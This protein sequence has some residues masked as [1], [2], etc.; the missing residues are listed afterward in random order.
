MKG[1]SHRPL[2]DMESNGVYFDVNDLLLVGDESL[3]CNY[4]GLPSVKSY[5]IIVGDE[6][7]E[8][9]SGHS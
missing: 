8:I 5:E 2:S 3:L 6:E 9:F 4:S 7:P 1:M